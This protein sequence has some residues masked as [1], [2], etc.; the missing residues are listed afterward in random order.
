MNLRQRVLEYCKRKNIAVSRFEKECNLANGYFNQVKKRPSLD[1]IESI[2]RAFPDLNTDWLLTGEGEMLRQSDRP[3][4]SFDKGVPYYNVDF[5][6]GFDLVINDQTILPEY[7]IDFRLYNQATCWCN[8]TGHSMEPEIAS[9]D[10]IALKEVIDPSFLPF[11]EIYAIITTNGMRTI[12]RIGPA[13]TSDCYALI[14]TNKSPEYGI[15]EI[16]KTMIYKVYEVLGCM[17]KL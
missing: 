4:K 13:S 1:K 14:P 9:G 7:L 11:G 16:P 5:L 8:I 3:V 10:I 17:K 15:Q 2:S 6:G 12:K